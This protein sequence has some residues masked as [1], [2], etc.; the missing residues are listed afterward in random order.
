[1]IGDWVWAYDEATDE[2]GLFPVTDV[3]VHTDPT[4]VHLL[5]DGELLET[6]PEHPFYTLERGWVDAGDLWVGAHIRQADGS[7][8]QVQFLAVERE[9]QV[10]Y[11]LTVAEAHTFFVGA[12]RW[13]VHNAK[14]PNI[15]R[16]PGDFEDIRDKHTKSGRAFQIAE[17]DKSYFYEPFSE[18]V[19]DLLID[20]AQGEIDMGKG[21]PQKNGKWRVDAQFFEYVGVNSEN[22]KATEWFRVVLEQDGTITTMHPIP[23]P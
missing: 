2:H 11:N 9:D 12:Q 7:Y 8:G 20:I 4:Q 16:R 15:D 22:N 10:M 17:D 1:M 18:E 6:T 14:C 23:E 21:K 19:F 5:L 3:I 13:L